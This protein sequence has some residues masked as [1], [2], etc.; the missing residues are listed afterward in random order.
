MEKLE[1]LSKFSSRR[2]FYRSK[3]K[4]IFPHFLSNEKSFSIKKLSP[5]KKTHLD[6]YIVQIPIFGRVQHS[7]EQ[8]SVPTTLNSNIQSN[9]LM[10]LLELTVSLREKVFLSTWHNTS[11][12]RSEN[13]ILKQ[14]HMWNWRGETRKLHPESRPTSMSNWISACHRRLAQ[15]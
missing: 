11:H 1:M 12:L 13:F 2:F 4:S 10:F 8:F 6:F 5:K 7:V 15:I 9:E 3:E 14:A